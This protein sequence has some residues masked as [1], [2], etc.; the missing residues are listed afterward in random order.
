[1]NQTFD[2]QLWPIWIALVVLG[3]FLAGMVLSV[4]RLDDT[5][6]LNNAATY[7]AAIPIVIGLWMWLATRIDR[8]VM[9]RVVML[10]L[11]LSVALNVGLLILLGWA[12]L[13]GQATMEQVVVRSRPRE[14]ITTPEAWILPTPQE[15]VRQVFEEPVDAETPEQ[16]EPEI[17]QAS[18]PSEIPTPQAHQT[19]NP[20]APAI[21]ARP[22]PRVR[23][24]QAESVPRESDTPSQLRRQLAER[25]PRTAQAAAQ[26]QVQPQDAQPS[27]APALEPAPSQVARDTETP[28]LERRST[29]TEE[30]ASTQALAAT[31]ARRQA[32][33]SP[34]LRSQPA[35]TLPRALQRPA[36]TPRADQVAT[37]NQQAASQRTNE[38]AAEPQAT[39]LERQAP[40]A[41]LARSATPTANAVT[42][43][44][45][46]L[47]GSMERQQAVAQSPDPAVDSSD[48]AV[49]ARSQPRPQM[50]TSPRA[51][52]V[53]SAA[54]AT[55]SATDEPTEATMG[56]AVTRGEA[57][58]A[59]IGRSVN[60]QENLAGASA[61]ASRAADLARRTTQA[62]VPGATTSELAGLP[63][64]QGL[65][66][67]DQGLPQTN[68]NVSNVPVPSS[69]GIA[70]ATDVTASAAAALVRSG[71]NSR[72]TDLSPAGG[73]SVLDLGPT[74]TTNEVARSNLAS[75]GGTPD[76]E[77]IANV[78]GLARSA[79]ENTTRPTTSG[80]AVAIPD[81]DA[82]AGPTSSQQDG[83][84]PVASLATRGASDQAVFEAVAEGDTYVAGEVVGPATANHQIERSATSVV[85]VVGAASQAEPGTAVGRSDMVKELAIDSRAADV[86][87]PGNLA[88]A[89]RVEAEPMEATGA[90][91]DRDTV[92]LPRSDWPSE[93]GA[94]AGDL[95]LDIS[96]S[97]LDRREVGQS[98]LSPSDQESPW[99]GDGSE[100]G[101]LVVR[102]NPAVR[103]L[104]VNTRVEA[105]LTETVPGAAES[106][107][108]ANNLAGG[109]DEG[110]IAKRD[111]DS[112][113]LDRPTIDGPAG[114]SVTIA[115]NAGLRI[116]RA[117]L[118]SSN[119]DYQPTRFQRQ[120]IGS[121]VNTN[122][123]ADMSLAAFNRRERRFGNPG[124]NS[125]SQPPP[126]TEEAIELGLV[127]LS[128]HQ[129]PD[130]RWSLTDFARGK[131]YER[132]ER[133]SLH[134]DTAATGLALLSFL[135]AGYHH[136]DDKY[137][138]VVRGAVEYL[139]RSQAVDGN[140]YVADD[141]E[142]AR[143]VALYSHGIATLALCEAFG[144]TQD[145]ELQEP[146]QRAIDYILAAQSKRLGGWRYA[147]GL[148]TDTSVT[149]W[150]VMALKSGELAQ[151]NVPADAYEKVT[152]WL[153]FA[154]AGSDERYL[155]RYNPLAPNNERQRH[156]REVT[157]VM[158]SVGLLSRMYL[159]WRRDN[160]WMQQGGDHL[161]ENLPEIGTSANPKRDTY[162]WYYATQV[163][164]HLGGEHWE[165]WNG[166]LHPILI[167]SQE[168]E[169][170]LAGSWNPRRPVP[171]R[172]AIHAGRLYVT[173]M[174]LLSLEVYYRHLPLYEETAK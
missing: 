31:L 68:A 78:P 117:E 9:R 56:E 100:V 143:S 50:N 103:P 170:P 144:M 105:P 164:F 128:R 168:Q 44:A 18:D 88:S 157:D 5:R 42:D 138:D 123:Q 163:M 36:A 86:Q 10:S 85:D 54:E 169:G 126:K 28:V 137:K 29:Q 15:E 38:V 99:D 148:E 108:V 2:E 14:E 4:F 3:A 33:D 23:Q 116:A 90:V 152:R 151:L 171:D 32:D 30:A 93:V 149:G 112:L 19:S 55:S 141:A 20:A 62:E 127:F 95:P 132:Q 167:E 64:R 75:G 104:E 46:S 34:Q 35:P 124:K 162:Y 39:Q 109:L 1:V 146:A 79:A 47:V 135:G 17:E 71:T 160:A 122:L 159:G 121:S 59:G 136:Q 82:V 111:D 81:T 77:S 22:Q 11:I 120:D 94:L 45:P 97:E 91:V 25:A 153:D 76:V 107:P 101:A 154:Q 129:S 113:L 84:A 13:V 89:G 26:Q 96:G 80:G 43:V 87:D 92:G 66:R 12:A 102:S 150:M 74:A 147:P 174:N 61:N 53:A 145:P 83:P 158:T 172:W 37:A 142:S 67:A 8:R 115:S 57:G 69:P 6:V 134:S 173:T 131:E 27:R 65:V 140:L 52:E 41:D 130:G 161:L 106:A 21:H 49:P 7:L 155:Y 73:E 58:I 98:V 139:L 40:A 114:L 70:V 60:V 51:S 72:A 24:E 119:L 16:P 48:A 165:Q 156:G 118:E 125:A 166:R 110:S 133:T 63:A